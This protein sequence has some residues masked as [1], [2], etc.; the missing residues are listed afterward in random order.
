MADIYGVGAMTVQRALRELQQLR[1]TYSVAG[2]GTFVHPDIAHLRDD[3]PLRKAMAAPDRVRQVA[4]YLA[5]QHAILDRHH[6]ATASRDKTAAARELLELA[7]A[8]LLAT[9]AQHV[10]ARAA[11]PRTRHCPRRSPRPRR[12]PPRDLIDEAIKCQSDRGNFAKD[13]FAHRRQPASEAPT[14]PTKATARKRATG[15]SKATGDGGAG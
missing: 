15:A 14:K 5:E 6:G 11:S 12:T 13:P 7:Q 10:P 3:G 8:D 4:D 9:I 1:V 2:K